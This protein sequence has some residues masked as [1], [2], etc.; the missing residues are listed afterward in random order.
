[1]FAGIDSEALAKFYAGKRGI[2]DDHL[3]GLDCPPQ[4]EISR[5]E[6]DA[7]IAEP[8]MALGNLN[9]FVEWD[10]ATAEREFKRAIELNPGDPEPWRLAMQQATGVPCTTMSHAI[11]AA[12]VDSWIVSKRFVNSR[13]SVIRRAARRSSAT[14]SLAWPRA[15]RTRTTTRTATR[16]FM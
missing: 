1:M 5:E 16:T 7:T 12:S 11:V 8:H 13:A 9:L 3:V 14:A 15:T 4:E 6:Y 10:W 2:A